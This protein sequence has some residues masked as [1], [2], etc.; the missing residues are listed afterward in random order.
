LLEC[1]RLGRKPQFTQP[2]LFSKGA[3]HRLEIVLCTQAIA[4]RA[5]GACLLAGA[6][7]YPA[8]DLLPGSVLAQ[9]IIPV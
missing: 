6:P 9:M 5:D 4:H 8:L 2:L 1:Y 7:R 3:K